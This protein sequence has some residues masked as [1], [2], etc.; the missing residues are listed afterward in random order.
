MLTKAEAI[1]ILKSRPIFNVDFLEAKDALNRFFEEAVN[2]EIKEI[3]FYGRLYNYPE[4]VQDLFWKDWSLH[5]VPSLQKA[6]SKVTYNGDTVIDAIK[7]VLNEWEEASAL[8]K[9]AKGDV[10]KGRKPVADSDRKTKIRTIENTGTC[11][12]CGKNVKIN[13]GKMVDHGF[14]LYYGWRNGN[15]FGVGRKPWEV[16]LQGRIDY[17]TALIVHRAKVAEGDDEDRLQKIE[18]ITKDIA[19]HQKLVDGWKAQPLP[20]TK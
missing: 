4:N 13:G 18:W 17:I 19:Y 16:S 15:C 8:V 1:E 10:I 11:P 14:T 6:V 12:C 7:R 20:G 3:Y 9:S 2:D 5:R